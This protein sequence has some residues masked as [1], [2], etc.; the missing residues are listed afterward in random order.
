MIEVMYENVLRKCNQCEYTTNDKSNLKRHIRS[1]HMEKD[2]KCEECDFVTDRKGLLK[3]HV[4][5]KNTLKKCDES[6]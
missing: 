4:N 5:A 6:E 1:K 3:K 2:M